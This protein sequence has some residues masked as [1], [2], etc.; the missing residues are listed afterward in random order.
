MEA[1]KKQRITKW[2]NIF[3]LIINISAIMT[4]LLAGRSAPAEEGLSDQFSSDEFLRQE[5]KL[6][7]EQFKEISALDVKI[8]RIY[9]SIID[10]QCEQQFKLLAELTEE[11]PNI[12]YMDSLAVTIGRLH[13]GIKRQTIRHFMNIRT[14]VDDEQEA[15][16]DQL[17]VDMMEMNR[18]CQFCNKTDCDRR[19]QLQ[20]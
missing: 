12:E 20:K 17:L 13:T 9:Q 15:L 3:L 1:Q 18:Q 4:I 14:V 8:F 5:L 10:M 2:L 19:K 7:D 16:L 11:E 6:S